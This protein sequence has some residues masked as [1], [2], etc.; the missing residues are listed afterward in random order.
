MKNF[1]F[2]TLGIIIIASLIFLLGYLVGRGWDLS[3]E[4]IAGPASA[5]GRKVGKGEA[6]YKPH[7]APEILPPKADL[8]YTVQVASSQ[9]EK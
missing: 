5:A 9:R 7:I 6:A 8:P 3:E 2:I 4:P 1:L